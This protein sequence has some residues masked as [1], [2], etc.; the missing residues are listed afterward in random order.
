M[1]NATPPPAF[2]VGLGQDSHQ[3]LPAKKNQTLSLAGLQF[4][5]GLTFAANS[6]GDVILHALCNALST[7]VGGGSF[8]TVADHL[9]LAEKITDS[10]KYL[11]VFLRLITEKGYL[12]NNISVSL[13]ALQP[14]LEK[15]RPQL[16]RS[17]ANLCH[18]PSAQVGLAFTTG[19]E[20]TDCGRGQGINCL[21]I[22][23]LVHV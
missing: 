23:S 20:L 5:C 10:K 3:L 18:L 17:L 11:E 15:Y 7:A 22:I 19:E 8:S 12:I 9:C 14:K 21:V 4:A 13:E 1:S 6:D 16:Q 2:L